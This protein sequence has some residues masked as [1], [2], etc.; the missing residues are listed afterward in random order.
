MRR[1]VIVLLTVLAALSVR[2]QHRPY[3]TWAFGLRAG[4]TGGTSG[5][6]IKGFIGETTAI[7]GIIGYWHG[8]PAGTLLLEKYVPA[9]RTDG[10][11]WYFGG[12]A[13]VTGKTGFNRWYVIDR[14][15]YDYVNAGAGYG[16]DAIAGLEYKVPAAPV[17]FSIDLKPFVEF[18]N[19]G[20][21]AMAID[22][23]VAVKIAF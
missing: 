22:P 4:A 18:S 13:H 3:Y 16:I 20:G 14:R 2:A 11:N 6:A 21:F 5:L 12:G 8:A 9:F 10:L 17:A 23:G 7:E 19:A 15:G 1:Y